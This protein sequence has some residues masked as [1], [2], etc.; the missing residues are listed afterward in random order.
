[1]VTLW[2]GSVTSASLRRPKS[3]IGFTKTCGY[4][5]CRL[6]QRATNRTG[7]GETNAQFVSTKSQERAQAVGPG[8]RSGIPLIC[9]DFQPFCTD[10]D[11]NANVLRDRVMPNALKSG[12][13]R[14]FNPDSALLRLSFRP[15]VRLRRMRS[16]RWLLNSAILKVVHHARHQPHR[17]VLTISRG[18]HGSAKRRI[19]LVPWAETNGSDTGDI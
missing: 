8:R 2:P 4:I 3:R 12:R 18:S 13:A 10:Q 14:V 17:N 5:G 11:E 6:D 16:H 7:G 19:A 1:M 9:R 15:V